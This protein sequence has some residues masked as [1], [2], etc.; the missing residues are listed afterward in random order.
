MKT[1]K[2]NKNDAGQRLDK[3][4]TKVTN[5][6]PPPLLYKYIR[7]KRIKINGK[8]AEQNTM[9]REGDVVELYIPDEFFS[10]DSKHFAEDGYIG[11]SDYGIDGE[12][13]FDKGYPSRS[14]TLHI[15]YIDRHKSARIKHFASDSNESAAN[16][17]GKFM[18]ALAKLSEWHARY[19]KEV[20]LTRGLME[21][22]SYQER[23]YPGAGIVKKMLVMHQLEL[24]KGLAIDS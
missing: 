20:P 18:E 16:P 7:T 9:L 4:V 19:V 3:F 13:Y 15:L 8:R 12:A 14:V 6:L 23:G 5:A 17:A 1:I 21:L 22:L 11:Y 2:I 10:D 24:Y